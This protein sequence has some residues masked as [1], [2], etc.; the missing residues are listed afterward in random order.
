MKKRI[1][2]AE[3]VSALNALPRTADGRIIYLGR[4]VWCEGSDDGLA[5]PH[6]VEVI[7]ISNLPPDAGSVQVVWRSGM[8]GWVSAETLFAI[9]PNDKTKTTKRRN[10]S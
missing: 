3:R 6:K 5:G 4:F 1:S 7:G 8:N 10:R 9:R 2:D